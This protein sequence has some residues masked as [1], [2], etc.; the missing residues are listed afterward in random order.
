MFSILSCLY[1]NL[2]LL[3]HMVLLGLIYKRNSK[4][5]PQSLYHLHFQH[6]C[7]RV[8]I[9]PY[10]YPHYSFIITAILLY[11]QW[12]LLE[13]LLWLRM[14]NTSSCALGYLDIFFKEIHIQLNCPLI[15]W[16]ILLDNNKCCVVRLLLCCKISLCILD[17][18]ALWNT[19]YTYIF[20]FCELY[21]H[22]M[23][24]PILSLLFSLMYKIL[25]Q[26]STTYLCFLFMI[27][28]LVPCNEYLPNPNYTKSYSY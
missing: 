2:G 19:I 22:L 3:Y 24:S 25:V 11:V 18:A 15:Y 27:V 13:L 17:A 1:L 8:Q 26:K 12:F 10:S 5:F 23:L 21:F 9:A 7:K 20:L 4:L 14:L 6:E 28:F 16:I